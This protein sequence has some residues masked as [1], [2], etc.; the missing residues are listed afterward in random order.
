MPG[1]S[2]RRMRRSIAAVD[3]VL[4]FTMHCIAVFVLMRS[5]QMKII[6]DR[7]RRGFAMRMVQRCDRRRKAEASGES[8]G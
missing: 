3:G 6:D 8:D 2:P 7:E 5:N 1:A 4:G